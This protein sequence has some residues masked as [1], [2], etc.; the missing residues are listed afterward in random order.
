MKK[1]YSFILL[2]ACSGSL[3]A[4]IPT[5][6]MES[7]RTTNA[8]GSPS[9]G[10]TPVPVEAAYKWYGS[11][12]TIIALG[13]S[14][15]LVLGS[16]DADWRKQIFKESTIVHGGSFS[17][18]IMTREEFSYTIPG[19]LA[20]AIPSIGISIV[21]TPTVTAV[22]L[23]GG[24]PI[25]AKPTSV[26]AWVQY[27]PGPGGIDSGSLSVQ[28]LGQVGGKDSVIGTGFVTI[29]QSSSWVQVTANI[30]YPIHVNVPADTFRI[31]LSSG[32][33]PTG[34]DSS[35]LYADDLSMITVPNPDNSGVANINGINPVKIYP[36]PASGM[37]FISSPQGE[38]LTCTLFTI[39][40]QEIL[41]KALSGED[42]ADISSL[43]A[44]IYLYA[45]KD[46]NGAVIQSGKVAINK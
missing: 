34:N 4:Q 20:N 40:G 11:D 22:S 17:A 19:V 29:G 6:D 5:D 35:T 42:K 15:N 10:H 38:N 21:P 18:K 41:T 27:F 46:D 37:L 31:A 28:V 9:I 26:S 39:S 44:G 3:Y 16:T 2:M 12:S 30:T 13:Q 24:S 7:W 45:I 36:N 43:P 32:K 33:G 23:K 25:S 1:I 14:L 8:V